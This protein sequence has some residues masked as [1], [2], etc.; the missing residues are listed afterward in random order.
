[1][2]VITMTT[3]TKKQPNSHPKSNIYADDD[4]SKKKI[5]FIL[6]RL[7]PVVSEAALDRTFSQRTAASLRHFPPLSRPTT[8]ASLISHLQDLPSAPRSTFVQSVFNA[9]NVLIGVGILSL[10]LAFRCAGW[11]WGTTIFLFCAFLTNYTAK[12]LA[13]CLDA[14]AG[15]TTYGDMGAAAFGERGRAFIGGVFIFELITIK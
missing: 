8:V 3:T 2:K 5:N 11:I 14:Y 9:V 12:L 10:P 6:E 15:A 7:Y 4:D 13:R 1:M